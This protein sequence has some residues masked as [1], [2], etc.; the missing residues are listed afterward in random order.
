M[1]KSK[2]TLDNPPSKEKM[3]EV[4]KA[5][6]KMMPKFNE[7]NRHLYFEV[8]EKAWKRAVEEIYAKHGVLDFFKKQ[9]AR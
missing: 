2:Y 8:R 1:K 5:I 7:Q 9:R 3:Q 4:S 6:G